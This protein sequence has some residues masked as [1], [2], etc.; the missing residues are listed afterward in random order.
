MIHV[1]KNLIKYELEPF[2]PQGFNFHYQKL[3]NRYLDWLFRHYYI[4]NFSE[5][6]YDFEDLPEE[7]R[8]KIHSW[9]EYYEKGFWN[10]TQ[11]D[12]DVCGKY[13]LKRIRNFPKSIKDRLDL[14]Q[15]DN[16]IFIY[17]YGR[18]LQDWKVD[19]WFHFKRKEETK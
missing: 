4:E 19:F 18:D 6:F 8:I 5:L 14:A 17:F 1:D 10:Y 13:T 2:Q 15:K 9:E 7:E 16:K 11:H 12:V 3:S